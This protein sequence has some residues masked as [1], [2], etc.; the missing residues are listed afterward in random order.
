M[1]PHVFRHPG[2]FSLSLLLAGTPALAGDA[3]PSLTLPRWK[4]LAGGVAFARVEATRYCRLGSVGIAVVRLD[5]TRCRLEPYHELEFSDQATILDWEARLKAPVV[6]N[7]G[8]YDTN[9]RHLGTLRRQGR[10]LGGSRHVSW[11]GVLALDPREA[12]LPPATLL[13]LSSPEDIAL[14]TKYATAVQSMMLFDRKGDIRVRRTDR[15]A[16]RSAVALDR[17]GRILL[18]VT[19]GAY[20]LWDTGALLRESGWDLVQALALD[21]G[22]EASLIVESNGVRYRSFENDRSGSDVATLVTLP[23]ILAVRLSNAPARRP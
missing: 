7:A 4:E 8:L 1:F 10:D 12:G 9:R 20:T 19:E 14:E 5:P 22:N 21:G 13:D 17:Q 2:F 3:D 11:K 18:L 16:R 6:L 23:A 15:I